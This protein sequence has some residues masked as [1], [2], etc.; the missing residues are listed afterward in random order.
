M[1]S[2]D[3]KIKGKMFG[4]I[5]VHIDDILRFFFFFPPMVWEAVIEHRAGSVSNH[6]EAHISVLSYPD[7]SLDGND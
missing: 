3:C 7:H 4:L 6:M 1:A 5:D 2:H